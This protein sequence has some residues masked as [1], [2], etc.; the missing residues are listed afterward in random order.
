MFSTPSEDEENPL[1]SSYSSIN[2][3][4]GETRRKPSTRRVLSGFIPLSILLE[5]LDP[6]G[7]N[8]ITA[9]APKKNESGCP[10]F[11]SAPFSLLAESGIS[12]AYDDDLEAAR[13]QE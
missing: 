5:L 11:I 8:S 1:T 12:S 9:A 6:S 10:S 3:R 2:S 4:P 13:C 7:M